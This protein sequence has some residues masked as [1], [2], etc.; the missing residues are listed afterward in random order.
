[1]LLACVPLVA[2]LTLAVPAFAAPSRA[3]NRCDSTTAARVI[4]ETNAYRASLGLSQLTVAPKLQRFAK[5]H[6]IDMAQGAA[7]T[8]SSSDGL[9]FA[10]RAHASNYRFFTMLENIAVEGAPFPTELGSD[11]VQLWKAS[12]AHDT[13]MRSRDISQI[14]VAVAAGPNACYA[15]MDLGKPA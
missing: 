8:H 3:T 4:V 14:G 7:L 1:M 2:S 5:S 9:S 11:L 15:S 13:N 12:P 6:A 10:E